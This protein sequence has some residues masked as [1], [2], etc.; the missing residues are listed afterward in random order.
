MSSVEVVGVSVDSVVELDSAVELVSLVC[1]EL[2]W[3]V[4]D[5]LVD[6]EDSVVAMRAAPLLLSLDEVGVAVASSKDDAEAEEASDKLEVELSAVAVELETLVVSVALLVDIVVEFKNDVGSDVN[7]PFRRAVELGMLVVSVALLIDV[8]VELK[9]DVG[10]DVTVP[11]RGAVAVGVVVGLI[12]VG[13][14]DRSV[15]GRA[16]VVVA[17]LVVLMV[18]VEV[19]VYRVGS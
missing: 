11:F 16:E 17:L 6:V 13:F 12:N 2:D 9:S 19:V 15:D 1:S 4:V 14:I 10:S 7:V 5:G 18:V 8:L 3:S